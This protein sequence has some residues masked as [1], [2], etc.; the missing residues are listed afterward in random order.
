MTETI[1]IAS[2]QYEVEF[3]HGWHQFEKKISDMVEEA[4]DNH[5]QILLFPEYACMELTSLFSD[6][7]DLHRQLETMQ[8]LLKNYLEIFRRLA[9]QHHVHISAGT[10]PVRLDNS[11][12]RNRSW[13]FFPDDRSDYQDKRMLTR[14]EKEKWGLTGIADRIGVFHTHLGIVG[15]NICYDVEFPLMAR[16]QAEAGAEIILVPSC[17][18]TQ[19]GFYRVQTGC[20]ARALENQC[21][22]VQ[23]PLVGKADWSDAID[24]NIGAAGVYMPPVHG[25][26]EDGILCVGKFDAKGW[27]Y[28]DLDISVIREQRSNGSVL[29]FKDWADQTRRQGD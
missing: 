18:D 6:D 9:I 7:T 25:Y 24:V 2:A 23:S 12:Y 14:F 27:L 13:F 10:F 19:A 5:A 8:T 16:A 28:A 17:T 29:N 21:F 1:R 22:V 20:R 4:V 26:C 11:A 3:I 15:V